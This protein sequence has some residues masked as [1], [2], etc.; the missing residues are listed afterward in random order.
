MLVRQRSRA[1]QLPRDIC[2]EED[3]NEDGEVGVGP[4]WVDVVVGLGQGNVGAE[5]GADEVLREKG[6]GRTDLLQEAVEA[7]KGRGVLQP[8]KHAAMNKHVKLKK[9]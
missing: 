4:D 5:L 7:E 1:V 9:S 6:L 8:R 2:D 3:E